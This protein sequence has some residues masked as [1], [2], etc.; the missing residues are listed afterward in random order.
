MSDAL[1]A[2][3]QNPLLRGFSDDGVRI[4]HAATTLRQ[5]GAGAPIFLEQQVGESAY[6][7]TSG[8]VQISVTRGG[9]ARVLAVL[10]APAS[11]GEIALLS[12]GTRRVSATAQTAVSV[13]EIPRRDFAS[14]QKQR[15]QACMKLMVNIMQNF[16]ERVQM[17]G[18]LLD[19][20]LP[21]S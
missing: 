2:L 17:A 1:A 12:P 18:P 11:F 21:Q 15:P 5:F 10:N 6:L 7:L 4:I 14:L 9:V 3:K 16:S 13:F 20:L 8:S 19:M